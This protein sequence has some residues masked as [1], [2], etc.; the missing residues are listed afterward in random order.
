M[1]ATSGEREGEIRC[2][3]QPDPY[4]KR[5]WRGEG[6]SSKSSG[7]KGLIFGGEKN[8]S[9]AANGERTKKKKIN[10]NDHL[11]GQIEEKKETKPPPRKKKRT[12]LNGQEKSSEEEI[13]LRKYGVSQRTGDSFIPDSEGGR[14]ISKACQGG[15]WCSDHCDYQRIVSILKE[16]RH[17]AGEKNKG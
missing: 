10:E 15:R 4:L 17:N 13:W 16:N 9:C 5:T 11:G 2:S 3:L 7:G 1:N 14:S 8:S 12:I 6:W